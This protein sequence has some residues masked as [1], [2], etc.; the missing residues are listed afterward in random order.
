M[1]DTF[2]KLRGSFI[3]RYVLHGRA[4]ILK[5]CLLAFYSR[6]EM[7]Q[8]HD[9]R[10]VVTNS[11]MNVRLALETRDVNGRLAVSGTDG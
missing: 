10:R 4:L 1:E 6:L 9:C 8:S 3:P 11:N 5:S 7:T 2:H